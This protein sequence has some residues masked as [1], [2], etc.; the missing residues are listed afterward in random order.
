MSIIRQDP[1]TKEWVIMATERAKRPHEFKKTAV[2]RAVNAHEKTRPFCAGNEERTPPE[3]LRMDGEGSAGWAVRVVP[4]RFSALKMDGEP[5][6]REVGPL[7]RN[8]NG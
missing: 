7:F 5:L 8:F 2:P 4:N 3:V 6:R 1:T